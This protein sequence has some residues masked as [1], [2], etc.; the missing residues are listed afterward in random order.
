MPIRNPQRYS[1][2]RRETLKGIAAGAGCRQLRPSHIRLVVH[3]RVGRISRALLLRR[4]AVAVGREVGNL[5][6]Y[7]LELLVQLSL[8]RQRAQLPAARQSQRLVRPLS[9]VEQLLAARIVEPT[10][11]GTKVGEP[12]RMSTATS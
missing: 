6:D 11:R 1:P 2:T 10:Q 7:L 8:V 12:R 9:R 4:V 3:R 5:L